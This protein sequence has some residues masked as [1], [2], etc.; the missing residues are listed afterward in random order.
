MV[1]KEVR[2]KVKCWC[3]SRAAALMAKLG[4]VELRTIDGN[5]S[6]L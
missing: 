4:A 5:A 1:L 3:G 6:P 2:G